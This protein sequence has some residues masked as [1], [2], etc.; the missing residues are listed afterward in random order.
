MSARWAK[1]IRERFMK[2]KY[3]DAAKIVK[4]LRKKGTAPGTGSML[5]VEQVVAS[6]KNVKMSNKN[7][8]PAVRAFSEERRIIAERPRRLRI[9]DKLRGQ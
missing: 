6:G 4:T 8:H 7:A 5:T 2:G 9:V 3:S 1:E